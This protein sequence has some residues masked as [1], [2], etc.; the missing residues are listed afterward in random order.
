MSVPAERL[1]AAL[2]EEIGKASKLEHELARA[3]VVLRA[4]VTRLRVG[5]NPELVM[6]TL[7]Y[8]L[9]QATV[10][11]LVERVD[12]V[13]S[14]HTEAVLSAQYGHDGLTQS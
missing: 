2:E 8:S 7:R 3:R 13:L 4:Q 12:P 1:V 6:A 11:A 9:P 10:L 5:A 14:A